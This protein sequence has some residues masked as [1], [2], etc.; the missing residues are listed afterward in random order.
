MDGWMDGFDGL[1][2]E[3]VGIACTVCSC[4]LC[5]LI[6]LRRVARNTSDSPIPGALE[7]QLGLWDQDD[8]ID[9][10]GIPSSPRIKWGGG[11]D[12]MISG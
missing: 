3:W 12:D 4:V 9:G 1:T 8:R 11:G 5:V 2:D 7:V 10:F 6:V